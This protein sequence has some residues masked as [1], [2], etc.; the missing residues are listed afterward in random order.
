MLGLRIQV[1][2]PNW[3]CLLSR[4][5]PVLHSRLRSMTE[6]M[7]D[8]TH[9]LFP[10]PYESWYVDATKLCESIAKTLPFE[11]TN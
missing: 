10:L 6:Y 1:C 2:K 11:L 4:G 3:E 8:G 9:A 7:G 5:D